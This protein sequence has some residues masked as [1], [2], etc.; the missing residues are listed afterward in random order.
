MFDM[1]VLQTGRDK[2]DIKQR[3]TKYLTAVFGINQAD[4]RNLFDDVRLSKS[5]TGEDDPLGSEHRG[6][7][8]APPDVQPMD[9]NESGDDRSVKELVIRLP[10]IDDGRRTVSTVS[11][12]NRRTSKYT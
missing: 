4:T 2:M 1:V 3:K 6:R 5:I 11:D 7:G 12:D 10:Q 9:C 8:R